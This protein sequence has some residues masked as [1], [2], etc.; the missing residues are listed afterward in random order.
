MRMED[1]PEAI[2]AAGYVAAGYSEDEAAQLAEDPTRRMARAMAGAI[3][4][5]M[6]GRER[7][8]RR[9]NVDTVDRDNSYYCEESC[10]HCCSVHDCSH[11]ES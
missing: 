2:F 6:D 10:P 11:C 9:Y 4:A 7:E 8:G 1:I 3:G 5:F